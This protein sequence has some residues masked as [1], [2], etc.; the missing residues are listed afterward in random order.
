MRQAVAPRDQRAAVEVAGDIRGLRLRAELVL[1]LLI[2]ALGAV[3]PSAFA[4][5]R[6]TALLDAESVTNQD[7]IT[8][9][10]NPVSLEQWAAENAGFTVTVRSGA[11]WEAMSA[12]EFAHYQVLIVGDPI[13]GSTAPSAVNSALTW[14]PVVMGEAGGSLTAGNRVLIGT[15]PE[16]H[17]NYGGGGATPR[18]AG[19]P[20]TAGAEHLVQDGI[21]YAGGA[22]GATGVYF[23]TSCS[24]LPEPGFV[25]AMHRVHSA[26][27]T[28]LVQE[29]LEGPDGRDVTEVLDHL[30]VTGPGHWTEDTGPPCGGS[31][32][33]IASNPAFD[34]GPTKLLDED[35]Q[36][37]GC[38]DHV[39]FPGFPSD[40]NAL[41][42]ATDTASHPTCGTDPDTSEQACG[43]AYVLLA[44]QGIVARATDLVLSPATSSDHAGGTH[45]LTA[46][47][48]DEEMPVAGSVVTFSVT[49]RNA[50]AE[51]MCVT[52]EGAADPNCETDANGVVRF[53]YG[54]GHGAGTDT[55]VASVKIGESTEQATAFQEWGGPPEALAPPTISGTPRQG[56]TLTEEH[57]TWTGK[58][59]GFAFSWLRCNASG[60][61]C[62][63]IGAT[64]QTY[65][66]R[67]ADLGHTIEVVERATNVVGTGEAVSSPTAVV[68]PTPLQARAGETLDTIAGSQVT[69]DGSGST[70]AESIT[71]YRWSFGDGSSGE[72]MTVTHTYT[73]PGT[74]TATLTVS[75]SSEEASA[76][77]T[78]TVAPKPVT[79]AE[80]TVEDT[81]AHPLAGAQVLYIDPEGHRTSAL[82]AA[83]GIAALPL[84]DGED[85]V[86]V[87]KEGFQPAVGH[88]TV[89]SGAGETTVQLTSGALV[90]ST[91][92]DHEMT[93]SEIEAAG[94]NTSDP[95]NQ[96]VYSFEVRLAFGEAS[97]GIPAELHCHVN[98]AGEFVGSCAP[99]GA[100][101]GGGEEGSEGGELGSGCSAHSCVFE[102]EGNPVVVKPIVVEGHPLIQ[103]LVLRGKVALL[104]QFATVTMTIQN[105]SPEPFVINHGSAQL[106][107]P[108]G[109]SLAPTAEPQTLTKAVADIPGMGSAS[110]SW[111][112]RGDDPGYYYLSATY[113]GMLQ[114]FEAPVTSLATFASPFHV[115]GSEALSLSVKA[116]SGTLQPGVP[117][118][119]TIGVTDKAT[120]P[121][122]NVDLSL[123]SNV[124]PSF[125]YQPDE[126][127]SDTIAELKPGQTLY[128]HRYVILPALESAGAF[129]PALSSAAF[130]GEVVHPG[131]GI[132][133]V[134]PPPLYSLAA[135][136]DTPYLIHLHWQAM[137]G[138][139]GYEV[140]ST[141]NLET[142]FAATPDAVATSPTG[143][144]TTAPLPASATDAYLP[145]SGSVR[146]YVVSTLISGVPTDEAAAVEAV[147]PGNK[148]LAVKKVSP[149]KGPASGGNTVIVTGSGFVGVK[150]VRFGGVL[151]SAVKVESESS[152]TA[153]APPHTTGTA[154][155]VITTLL[156][157]SAV[158]A[159]DQYVY[160][161]P[162]VTA[163]SPS[164]GPTSGGT[165]VSITG[166]GFAPGTNQ[167]SF[168]FGKTAATYVY[169]GSS[170][171][172]SATSPSEAAGTVDVVASVGGVAG[173]KSR[174]ADQFTFFP[175]PTVSKLN[176]KKGPAAGGTAVTIIGSDFTE[177]LSVQFGPQ[178]VGFSVKS[179]S[180]I[181]IIAP[182]GTS[183]AADVLVTTVAGTSAA[184]TKD[185][186]TYEAPTVTSISP[187][188]GA[189]AGGNSVSIWGSGFAAGAGNTSFLFGKT[190][191]TSVYCS[192]S[193]YCS[194]TVPAS[195]KHG[196]VT[197]LASVSNAKSKK[198]SGDQYTY[199]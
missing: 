69:L 160:G 166:S 162:T 199:E 122:Y 13:C 58:P 107:L 98:E 127:F 34:S 97:G 195:S 20:Q 62:I 105:L 24:D 60:E 53:T 16:F 37:W 46:T 104:K 185:Q 142:P 41:A 157:T 168:M 196:N 174:P 30:T 154:D 108:S 83:D 100:E 95:A 146:D 88:I 137:P 42:V 176:P 11:E 73:E 51:G 21:T 70:P 59:T 92:S 47:V 155:V 45:T 172:C 5:V 94:I 156:G 187:S 93:L 179:S 140:F 99:V 18:E 75:G 145:S 111:V 130:D 197:L 115:W 44:G 28:P 23:D 71:G 141:L 22:V 32:Q 171:S 40:W 183:G 85:S 133:A 3:A 64:G 50:G 116:D 186:Y 177:V 6:H 29:E 65:L 159:K 81:A 91:L 63:P 2:V 134:S 124:H 72:G 90:T 165:S 80:V 66:L 148:A 52:G 8:R 101:T 167:T 169:C 125:I 113:N 31:V 86:Y 33:Q 164:Q 61:G 87:Y 123:D 129:N 55:I 114:P 178:Y 152:L 14:T 128:S 175:A 76:S 173:K 38:S 43:E 57:G 182:A 121:L 67:Q 109:V 188:H 132:E 106:S 12:A 84:P 68:T 36:G 126:R 78:V 77:T 170:S 74:Y 35:I 144:P 138:A 89:K 48:T 17:Y 19:N 4:S 26:L 110:T 117:Y 191:A 10:G 143:T 136:P 189:R 153:V 15:D 82:S 79:E 180:E 56:E 119:V 184:S 193:S 112:V 54:D 139:E 7:G 49:G 161:A 131:S 151:A 9:D 150:S 103:W 25:T 102:V 120:I 149:K 147:A 194:A 158:S 135:V 181:A 163:V 118:H 190:A 27:A 39:T 192:S 198:G 1:A 96:H